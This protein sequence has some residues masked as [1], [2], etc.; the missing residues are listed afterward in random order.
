MTNVFMNA[1]FVHIL[2]VGDAS[3]IDDKFQHFFHCQFT[4]LEK[5]QGVLG[6]VLELIATI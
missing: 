5:I 2:C 1:P 4:I 6:V 3:I